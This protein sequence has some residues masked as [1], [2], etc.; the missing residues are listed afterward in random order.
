[1]YW[2]NRFHQ[3]R[4]ALPDKSIPMTLV[5]F[6]S[7]IQTNSKQSDKAESKYYYL[8]SDVQEEDR[9][10]RQQLHLNRLDYVLKQQDTERRD[11]S[12]NYKCFFCKFR[13]D[14]ANPA[15][16][17]LHMTACHKFQIGHP[18]NMVFTKEFLKRQKEEYFDLLKCP[19]CKK[20]FK[21]KPTL[22]DHMKKK[23]HRRLDPTVRFVEKLLFL[24][25]IENK[26]FNRG[27]ATIHST[28]TI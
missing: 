15:D 17:I 7:K 14:K 23:N 18:D 20:I 2:S 10:L 25:R 9:N 27:L 24:H 8:L 26:N 22:L 19:Y 3:T 13:I 28:N 11:R 6:C 21:D 1:M 5:Q 16:I 12:F 4:D